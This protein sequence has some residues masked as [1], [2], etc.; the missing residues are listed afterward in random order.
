MAQQSTIINH[1]KNGR[2]DFCAGVV[3]RDVI[4]IASNDT[5]FFSQYHMISDE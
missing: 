3:I 4:I 5:L 1:K 2:P